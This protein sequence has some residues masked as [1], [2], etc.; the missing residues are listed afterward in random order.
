MLSWPC[1]HALAH[2][3]T[4]TRGNSAF[5]PDRTGADSRCG[6]CSLPQG[7]MAHSCAASY[8]AMGNGPRMTAQATVLGQPALFTSVSSSILAPSACRSA[9][10]VSKEAL[11][12][13]LSARS[14]RHNGVRGHRVILTNHNDP[15]PLRTT[16]SPSLLPTSFSQKEC[17]LAGKVTGESYLLS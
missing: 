2:Q 15:Q 4:Q 3:L 6:M 13:C 9:N 12:D 7:Q 11:L 1:Q 14:R 10:R 5:G 16:H 17:T 8:L